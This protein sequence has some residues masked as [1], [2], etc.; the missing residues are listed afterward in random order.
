MNSMNSLK[1]NI[2]TL[3]LIIVVLVVHCGIHKSSYNVSNVA[4]Q[5]L[6]IFCA[7]TDVGLHFW[8]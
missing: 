6:N 2:R 7:Y 3:F 8:M 4:T 1:S 5:G